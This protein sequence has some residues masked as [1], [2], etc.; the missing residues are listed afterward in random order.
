MDTVD[1]G[2]RGAPWTMKTT[3]PP[4]TNLSLPIFLELHQL[5]DFKKVGNV[6]SIVDQNGDFVG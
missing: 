6:I 2:F 5:K 3:V 4:K 1:T